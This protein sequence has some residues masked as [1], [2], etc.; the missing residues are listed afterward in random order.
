MTQ[1][2]ILKAGFHFFVPS[3]PGL[4]YIRNLY[5][6]LKPLP[7]AVATVTFLPRYSRPT[8][9]HWAIDSLCH[10]PKYSNLLSNDEWMMRH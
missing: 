8:R 1:L 6:L 9:I 10:D 2:K 3:N 4:S 5:A 7:Y